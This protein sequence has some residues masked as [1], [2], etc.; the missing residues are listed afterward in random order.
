MAAAREEGDIRLY[1]IDHNDNVKRI[2]KEYNTNYDF[3]DAVKT[4][5]DKAPVLPYFAGGFTVGRD[6]KIGVELDGEAADTL[7]E[8]DMKDCFCIPV[9]IKN[10]ATGKVLSS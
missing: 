8:A 5:R 3:P 10:L 4:A 6:S 1:V 2:V 9:T 7:D